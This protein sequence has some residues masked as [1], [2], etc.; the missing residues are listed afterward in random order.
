MH[1][2]PNSES[3]H[4]FAE[5]VEIHFDV[6]KLPNVTGV[7]L[8]HLLWILFFKVG[9]VLNDKEVTW[10]VDDMPDILD[11]QCFFAW[12]FAWT[13][14]IPDIVAENHMRPMVP[15]RLLDTGR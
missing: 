7:E 3:K 11:P 10:R 2:I 15:N 6:F 14:I 5:D 8:V 12:T 13:S 9:K 4:P 1:S